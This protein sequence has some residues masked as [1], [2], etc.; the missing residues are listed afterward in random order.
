MSYD[1]DDLTPETLS[2]KIMN[3][4]RKPFIIQPTLRPDLHGVT[5]A[6]NHILAMLSPQPELINNAT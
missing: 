5:I 4:W 2:R 3:H 1:P 6:A